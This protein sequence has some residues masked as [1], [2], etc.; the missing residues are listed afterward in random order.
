MLGFI[1]FTIAFAA[2]RRVYY[3]MMG[4]IPKDN[5]KANFKRRI[6]RRQPNIDMPEAKENLLGGKEPEE[7]KKDETSI[8]Q[9]G[10]DFLRRRVKPSNSVKVNRGFQPE[11]ENFMITEKS[12]NVA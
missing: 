2:I 1:L 7:S 6:G 4:R 3:T 9:K 11:L 5:W 10:M 8:V 12:K